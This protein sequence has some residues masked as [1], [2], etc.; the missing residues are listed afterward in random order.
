MDRDK[1][2]ERLKLSYDAILGISNNRFESIES[3]VKDA[4]SRK[5][6]DEFITPCTLAD[7]KADLEKD[8]FV[9]LN[10]RADR[11]LQLT[12][13]FVDTKFE[14]FDRLGEAKN[15]FT[16]TTYDD[17]IH[18][19]VLFSNLD[20]NDPQT[21]SLENPMAKIIS[22][23][24]LTQFH[25]G[26]TEK[27]AHVTYFF[28]GGEKNPFP[29]QENKLINSAKVKSHDMY[30]QMR[31]AEISNEVILSSKKN[32]DFICAN[33]AN[34]DMVGHSGNLEACID[35]IEFLDKC[36]G[37]A[38][39][40]LTNNDYGVF[41]TSDHGNCDEMIDVRTKKINKEHTLNPVPFIYISRNNSGGYV[42]K[43]AFF[44][45]DPI[46]ILA[47]I[48]PTIMS[49][50]GISIPEEMSGVDLRGSLI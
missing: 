26:E 16:L 18:T 49:E 46:G 41:V 15:F 34:G 48:A 29:K 45:S 33:F 6:T 1:N 8:V 21:N 7:Y 10:Y 4:Y 11:A 38:V 23:N 25:V 30:P 19:K 24:E 47:D 2:W 31:A 12:R 44:Q 5:E 27:F 50:L 3:A 9:F 42:A 43:D 40:E 13:S 28:A 22:Q 39:K 37:T 14:E 35:S 36:I 17:N 32:F 20:L